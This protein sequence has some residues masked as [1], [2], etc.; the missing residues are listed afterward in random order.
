MGKRNLIEHLTAFNYMMSMPQFLNLF[1]NYYLVN[2]GFFFL[3]CLGIC[4][5]KSWSL[6]SLPLYKFPSIMDNRVRW[7]QKNNKE[8][9]GF[10]IK[11]LV[12]F[13]HRHILAT[14]HQLSQ[15]WN[16][17]FLKKFKSKKWGNKWSRFFFPFK[18]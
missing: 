18:L 11:P 16:W 15:F 8:S 10:P 6:G 2:K 4:L 7:Q 13:L 3:I 12:H 1:S 17:V 14:C 5:Q 9:R